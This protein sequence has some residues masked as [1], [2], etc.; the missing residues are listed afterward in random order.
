MTDKLLFTIIIPIFNAEKYLDRCIKSVLKQSYREFQV[1]LVDDGSKDRSGEICDYYAKHSS[2]ITV[3]H[4][5]NEGV[6]AARNDGIRVAEG[7]YIGFVDADD[8]IEEDCLMTLFQLLRSEYFDCVSFGIN[9]IFVENGEIVDSVQDTHGEAFWRN[10]DEI[11]GGIIE[12][13]PNMTIA[14][15]CNKVYTKDIIKN[16]NFIEMMTGEDFLFNIEVLQDISSFAVLN[17]CLYD[18]Y[19]NKKEKTR[20]NSYTLKY[21]DDIEAMYKAVLSLFRNW[22]IKQKDYYQIIDDIMYGMFHNVLVALPR[23]EYKKSIRRPYVRK[24]ILGAKSYSWK[25]RIYKLLL[26]MKA[27][28]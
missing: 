2:Q 9:K 24:A 7:D 19:R 15:V 16:K 11:R 10:P 8:T 27:F 22:E 3:I 20:A 5:Q 17:N 1:V 14:S 18:Y 13:F 25:E 28:V 26:L 23:E 12:L 6:S 21:I 4:K